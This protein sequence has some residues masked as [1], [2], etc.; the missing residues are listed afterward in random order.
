[1]LPQ[2]AL[3]PVSPQQMWQSGKQVILYLFFW[4][5]GVHDVIHFPTAASYQLA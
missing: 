2:M 5:A 4:G 1:M 3:V